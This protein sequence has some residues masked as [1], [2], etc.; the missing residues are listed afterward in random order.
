MRRREASIGIS[1]RNQ[2]QFDFSG[3]LSGNAFADFLL[4]TP[5]ETEF[6][7]GI[8]QNDVHQSHF[9]AY[10]QDDWKVTSRFTLNLGFRYEYAGS[11]VDV[12][13]NIRNFNWSTLSLFG[14]LG[15]REPINNP[16]DWGPRAMAPR[17]GYAYRISDKTVI[18]GGYG[19]F[20]TTPTEANVSVINSNPPLN[21]Q[22]FNFTNLQSPNLSLCCFTI[23]ATTSTQPPYG[24]L[25][26]PNDYGPGYSQQ[27]STN[28]QHQLPGG[29]VAEVGYFGSHTL[30]LDN[31]HSE[32]EWRTPSASNTQANRPYPQYLDIRVLG[33]DAVAY[34]DSLQTRLQTPVWHNLNLLTSYTYGHCI[35]T[36]SAAA[37]SFIGTEQ[38]EP[39]NQY[40]RFKG[41]RGDCVFDFRHQYHLNAVYA[42][43]GS[44]SK[45]AAARLIQGWS[46]SANLVLQSGDH[47]TV[48]LPGNPA[49]TGR[50][51]IRPD[52][53]CDGSLPNRT[54]LE[55]FNT[56][57][58]VNW[59]LAV[60]R[61]YKFGNSGRGVVTGPPT[62]LLDFSLLK[63]TSIR[64][65]QRFELRADFFNALNN[66]H[67]GDPDLTVGDATFG[68]ISTAGPGRQ[69]QVGA[70]Y[71]F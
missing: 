1:P 68:R 13:G 6:Q 51:S 59:S 30:N 46:V 52:R 3:Q 15:Q 58:F 38:Q 2:G 41:E 17:F 49:N 31:A 43:P 47:D 65:T 71:V 14:G 32:N 40:D 35:D 61:V 66:H 19:I 36:K 5:F 55:W 11:Y 7:Y 16:T 10:I 48:I 28:I 9:S 23:G 44:A 64:E 63:S 37:T 62:R 34:F 70:H 39:Q 50:G 45:S 53:V 24:I 22:N 33:T 67:F 25:S 29:W 27:W 18:R 4:G 57:C 42:I 20:I 8:N 69:I 54:Y 12:D 56:S 21:T 26:I 60:P